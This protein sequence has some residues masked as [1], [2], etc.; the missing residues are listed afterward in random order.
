MSGSAGRN[1]S[2]RRT[3]KPLSEVSQYVDFRKWDHTQ[4]FAAA[5]VK[6]VILQTNGQFSSFQILN[7]LPRLAL[8]P[9]WR[10]LTGRDAVL[11]ALLKPILDP[12]QTVL[13][14]SRPRPGRTRSP[15]HG[16][17]WPAGP[18]WPAA[19]PKAKPKAKPW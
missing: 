19:E 5:R 11:A 2:R 7:P 3:G 13:L 16:R 1:I 12:R 4:L 14:E 6:Y 10:M 9:T 15:F 18:G 8:V 17:G